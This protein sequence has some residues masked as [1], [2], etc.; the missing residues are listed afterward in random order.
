MYIYIYILPFIVYG[1]PWFLV[2]TLQTQGWSVSGVAI[3]SLREV[4]FCCLPSL[5][6]F[7]G[8]AFCTDG[9]VSRRAPRPPPVSDARWSD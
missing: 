3:T 6:T 5:S 7:S 1:N 9:V 4:I 8:A 2:L